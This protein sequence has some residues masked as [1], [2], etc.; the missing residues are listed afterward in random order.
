MEVGAW[1]GIFALRTHPKIVMEALVDIVKTFFTSVDDRNWERTKATMTDNVLLDYSSMSG[2]A[3]AWISPGDIIAGWASFLPG[4]NK[5]QHEIFVFK[6]DAVPEMATV[7]CRGK[8][9][10]F[11]GD[12]IWTV[13]GNYEIVLE[14]TGKGW[15]IRE[16][17]FNFIRESGNARLPDIARR[18]MQ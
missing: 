9:D 12:E 17:K 10:H 15:L 18:R 7:H 13:E 3:A 5:T 16:F 1:L 8:A 11:V 14:S 6:I 4:F 2:E